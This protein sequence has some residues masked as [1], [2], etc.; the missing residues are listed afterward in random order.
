MQLK[1]LTLYTP[2]L[3]RAIEFYNHT[4]KFPLLIKSFSSAT[5]RIG[6]TRLTFIRRDEHTP[7]HLAINIPSNKETE[8]CNWLKDR[9]KLLTHNDEEMI[10]FPEWESKAMFFHDMDGNIIEFIAR[11][12]LYYTE[13]MPFQSI[14]AMGISEIGMA[15]DDVAGTY[16]Q[17]NAIHPLNIFD[18]GKDQDF[19][20]AGNE[21]GLFII[22]NKN[23]RSWYPVDDKAYTSD[24]ILYGK[25]ISFKFLDGEIIP[26]AQSTL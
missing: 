1:K 7:Y 6:K 16:E 8:A 21:R 19:L 22:I 20:A 2:N 5:F 18:G 11:K 26:L 25:D 15:V 4:L 14:Q 24:F 13:S 10:D 12:N 23:T 17:L 9:V 3:E